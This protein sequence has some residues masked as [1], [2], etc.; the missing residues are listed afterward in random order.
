MLSASCWIGVVSRDHARIGAKG[1]FIQLN[2]GQ[3]APLKKLEAG[4]W[5]AIYSPRESYPDGAQLQAFTAIGWIE[6]GE[7]YRV[8][9]TSDFRPYRVV[10]RFMECKE[11]PIRPLLERLSFIKDKQHW[12]AAFRFGHV[13]VPP[14]DFAVIASA[15]GCMGFDCGG[16][17]R[18][19][20]SKTVASG[21]K[22]R[23]A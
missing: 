4:D 14:E 23:T 9:M 17:N 1:G 8:E 7:V 13:K 19:A 12:G 10:T 16:E 6:S 18:V 2:H 22:V 11:A 3:R 21:K 5:I 20:P 15:M